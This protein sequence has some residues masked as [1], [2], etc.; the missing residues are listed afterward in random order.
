MDMPTQ[1]KSYKKQTQVSSS[2]ASRKELIERLQ[3]LP[4]PPPVALRIVTM[5]ADEKVRLNALAELLATDQALALL[6]LRQAN[7]QAYGLQGGVEKLDH[8]VRVLGI[9]GLSNLMLSCAVRAP[10]EGLLKGNDPVAL[11]LW[12]HALATACCAELLAAA[13][14][15]EW[16][17]LAFGAGLLHDVGKLALLAVDPETEEPL[18]E[19][20]RTM[21]SCMAALEH[22]AMELSHDQA[23]KWLLESWRLPRQ[24]LE[25]VWLHHA[26]EEML[27]VAGDSPQLVRL[28]RLADHLAHTVMTDGVSGLSGEESSRLVDWLG[29][30]DA[31]LAEIRQKLGEAYA[32]RSSLFDL[33]EDASSFYYQALMR[34]NELLARRERESRHLASGLDGSRETMG[35][36]AQA[37]LDMLES[38]SETKVMEIAAR[39]FQG[40]L[41]APSGALLITRGE[42]LGTVRGAIT[43]NA[44]EGSCWGWYWLPEVPPEPFTL[45]P[46]RNGLIQPSDLPGEMPADLATPLATLLLRRRYANDAAK[47][48]QLHGEQDGFWIGSLGLCERKDEAAVCCGEVLLKLPDEEPSKELF[49]RA[50]RLLAV[51][52]SLLRRIKRMEERA[53]RMVS[54]A[55]EARRNDLKLLRAERLASV[56]QLAAGAAHE[57]NNPLSILSARMQVWR[58][59]EQDPK[60]QADLDAV[61]EQI[62]RIS[63][64][65]GNLLHFARVREP[66]KRPT[67][68]NE[69]LERVL[70]MLRG[71]LVKQGV[72]LE[73]ELD[74]NLPPI[75][76]DP[77]QLEQVFMNLLLNAQQAMEGR[78]EAVLRVSS[79]TVGARDAQVDISDT[80]QGIPRENLGKIFEP[81]YT[82]KA[83]KKGT[84][85]GLSTVLGILQ[86]HDGAIHVDSVVGVGSR[87]LVTLP[88][89]GAD[90]AES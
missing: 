85:L 14:R 12:R 88:I 80:G 75:E 2:P 25:C 43:N 27:D 71:Q 86:N 8:A 38:Q 74:P 78:E 67:Q 45:F 23:G 48:A 33:E 60:R 44:S 56:G 72:R 37:A 57:I 6:A 32:R 4:S 34:A 9:D 39:L 84:G 1:K 13:A 31:G 81:F 29:L 59:Q 19:E 53:E 7:V 76:A 18:L 51:N 52:I 42:S 40:A 70:A 30:D 87:V 62:S 64:I 10:M 82:T 3:H 50:T 20:S 66:G 46:G 54:A 68:V 77:G 11:E 90:S 36:L 15:P 79:R 47:T 63:S 69:V 49:A 28:V 5:A 83:E 35:A 55:G 61:L 89:G 24:L 17:Q 26:P 41:R 16:S 21:R 65:V 58:R 22:A 73:L